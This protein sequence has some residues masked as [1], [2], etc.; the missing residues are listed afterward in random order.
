MPTD[1]HTLEILVGEI[2][3]MRVDVTDVKVSVGRLESIP[4][5]VEAH[6][7]R[8]TKQEIESGKQA[9]KVRTLWAVAGAAATAVGGLV[10]WLT[11]GG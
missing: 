10:L 2:R 1:N 3:G 5:R 7:R 8:L 9:V 6:E 4:D 11:K